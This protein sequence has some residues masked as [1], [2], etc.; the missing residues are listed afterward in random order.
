MGGRTEQ[1]TVYVTEERKVELEQRAAD[2]DESVSGIINDMIARQL[3]QEA[4]DAIASEV[5]A[6]ERIQELMTLG[7]EE[8]IE[9]AREIRDMN[10]KFGTYA[11][12]N[13]ELMKQ[14][15]T[16]YERK[17]ALRTGARRL[18]QDL[19]TVAEDLAAET[20]DSTGDGTDATPT[21]ETAARKLA[22]AGGGQST[23]DSDDATADSQRSTTEGSGTEQSTTEGED[24]GEAD[25]DSLF[26]ELRSDRE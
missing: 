4:Q 8:M 3:Q 7:K 26:D 13:F 20:S 10:A 5:R 18:R 6:E 17:E 22:D 16:A 1:I 25:G 9:V 23:A 2:E 14:D 15:H 11:V 12:A 21:T 19:D 24:E